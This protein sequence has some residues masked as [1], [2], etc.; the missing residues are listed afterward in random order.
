MEAQ[1]LQLPCGCV[2]AAEEKLTTHGSI[3]ECPW[4]SASFNVIDWAQWL[5]G[6]DREPLPVAPEPHTVL[7]FGGHILER[8]G[9]CGCGSH[10]VRQGDT[11]FHLDVPA[12]LIET[13]HN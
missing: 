6:P 2:I 10:I 8:L 4:C 13:L 1:L 9:A 11:R 5:A 3:A 12:E 7:R